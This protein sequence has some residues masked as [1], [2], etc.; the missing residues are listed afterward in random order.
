MWAV[1]S[2]QLTNN[3]QVPNNTPLTLI[4][5]SM[6]QSQTSSRDVFRFGGEFPVHD[7]GCW[8]SKS[9]QYFVILLF[10]WSEFCTYW[11]TDAK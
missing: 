10:L 11:W 3:K 6:N 1:S 9:G 8:R 4:N 7:T 5:R 2:L